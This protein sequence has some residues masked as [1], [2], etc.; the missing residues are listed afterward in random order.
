MDD[1]QAIRQITSAPAQAGWPLTRARRNAL[2]ELLLTLVLALALLALAYG[3]PLQARFDVGLRPVPL[4]GLH[5]PEHNAD[6]DYAYSTG[7]TTLG[8][9]LAGSA[10]H[11]I[12]LRL[13]GPA[14]MPVETQLIAPLAVSLGPVA[15]PR[16][17]RVL[18]P[19]TPGGALHLR[20]GSTL[21]T[22]PAEPRRLG[23]LID[24]VKL[25]GAAAGRPNWQFAALFGMAA[26]AICAAG[27]RLGLHPGLAGVATLLLA[28]AGA[29]LTGARRTTPEAELL[30]L[31]L[32]GA[33]LLGGVGALWQPILGAARRAE[34]ACFNPRAITLSRWTL[35]IAVAAIFGWQLSR[36]ST[37]LIDDSY[38]SLVYAKN[39]LAG[40]G[41]TFNGQ[42]VAGYSN[43]LWVIAAAA[44]GAL[45]LGLVP[46]VKLMGM[47]CAC[48]VLLLLPALSRRSA[49]GVIAGLIAAVLLVCSTPFAVWSV[50]GLE[51]QGFTLLLLAAIL[52]MVAE[53]ERGRVRFATAPL[54]G[55]ALLRPEG[56][57]LAAGLMGVWALW[58]MWRRGRAGLSRDLLTAGG[59]LLAGYGLFVG[60]HWLYY[61]YPMPTTVYAKTGDTQRQIVEGLAYLGRYAA[62]VLPLPVLTALFVPFY[63]RR[64]ELGPLLVSAAAIAYSLFIVLAGGDWMPAFRFLVP[65]L[66]LYAL[67]VASAATELPRLPAGRGGAGLLAALAAIVLALA[68]VLRGEPSLSAQVR[69]TAGD[70]RNAERLAETIAARLRPGESVA[71]VDAGAIAYYTGAP[72]VDMVGLNDAY[73]ARLPGGF[74]TKFDNDYLLARAPTYVQI[75]MAEAEGILYP[76]NFEGTIRLF[77]T[78]EFRRWYAPTAERVDLFQRRPMP[79]NDQAL[80]QFFA[81]SIDAALPARQRPGASFDAVLT[82]ANLGELPWHTARTSPIGAVAVVAEWR[83]A[84]GVLAATSTTPL[85]A[86]LV[87]GAQLEL[88]VPLSAPDAPGS[89][90]L[91]IDL[92]RRAL[93]RFSAVGSPPLTAQI[94]VRE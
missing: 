40:R 15:A 38:I 35:A 8:L 93:Y 94:M 59:A 33:L 45:G 41:L 67:I 22:L 29:A 56:F 78:P 31:P 32:W 52:S 14:G 34:A 62:L 16:I 70:V 3:T 6:F 53:E 44:L 72:I 2:V 18:A 73:I 66:P 26:V 63:L 60:W 84:D 76:A 11:L 77:F 9:P 19:P 17:Y 37:F 55:L 57:A 79:L 90:T 42:V 87:P 21:V 13:A 81:S 64:L 50:A 68:G 39:L 5:A 36:Y 51:T 71:V 86:P 12:T 27:I 89:Y 69:A 20:L 48:G 28:G 61:G 91:T 74:L 75:H 85:P 10:P 58:R 43:F 88:Q 92:E 47:A 80:A 82:L 30:W 4:S 7:E 24:T 25:E 1:S 23:V 54:L 49:H 46:A 83:T 65:V